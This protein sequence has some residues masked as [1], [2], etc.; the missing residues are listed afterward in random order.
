MHSDVSTC[1]KPEHDATYYW[2]E[3]SCMIRDI[4]IPG[5]YYED[6]AT[7]RHSDPENKGYRLKQC[8]WT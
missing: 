5:T 4:S 7:S 6:P 8:Y 2:I 1:S 3:T